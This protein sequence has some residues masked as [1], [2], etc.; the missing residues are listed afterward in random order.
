[1]ENTTFKRGKHKGKTY[2]D[3]RI[4]YTEYFIYLIAQPAGNVYHH[5]DFIEYCME[6]I[7]AEDNREKPS[8]LVINNVST[9]EHSWPPSV[10]NR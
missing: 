6:Y 3:V 2:K 8:S 1:M 10:N 7:R 4:N 9:G 5:F